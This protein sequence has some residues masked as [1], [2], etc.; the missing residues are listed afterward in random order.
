MTHQEVNS[1]I[2]QTALSVCK[3]LHVLTPHARRK[4]KKYLF[5]SSLR[6][7]R[8]Q[9][10]RQRVTLLLADMIHVGQRST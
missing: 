6:S 8:F 3:N 4:I 10:G 2:V 7:A 1:K 5:L 9:H